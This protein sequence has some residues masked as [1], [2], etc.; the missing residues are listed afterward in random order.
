MALNEDQV[1]LVGTGRDLL[2]GAGTRFD[3]QDEFNPFSTQVRTPQSEDRPYEH[4]ALVGAEWFAER[5]VPI[6][7]IANGADRD[8]PSARRAIQD[9]SAAFAAVGATGEIA[10]LRFRL[11]EDPDE[12]VM[13]GRPRGIDPDTRAIGL[14]YTYV[15][16]A[17]VASD[18]RIYSGTLTSQT[19]G[20]PLQQGGLTLTARPSSTR[21]RLPGDAGAYAS[22]P[23]TAALDIT[24][25][26][27]IEAD[28]N[29]D[30]FA[31]GATQALVSKYTG[32]GNQRSYALWLSGT[33]QVQVVWSTDG[34]TA[35]R[36]IVSSAT[37]VPTTA[38][39][40]RGSLDVNNGAGQRVVTFSYRL[41]DTGPWIQFDQ[42]TIAG[43]TSV[44]AGTALLEIGA[45]TGGAL[46]RF[47]GTVRGARV[48]SVI[49]GTVVANPDFTSQNVKATSFVDSTGKTWTISGTAALV[50]G[51]T[52]RRGLTVPFTIPG[53]LVGGEL[54]LI[55]TGTTDT[56]LRVRI[57]GP[58]VEPRLILRRP[59]GTVQS[60]GF[61]L[62]LL[63]GQW[64]DV[65]SAARTALLNSLP[66][67]NQRGVADWGLDPYPIQPGTNTLRFTAAAYNSDAQITAEHRSAWW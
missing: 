15:S 30:N 47:T 6:R 39:G 61:D 31:T 29:A 41:T 50:G 34:T 49:G 32:T 17:F 52:Y 14:G 20:L 8:V 35:G 59:D 56:G 3:V 19:A 27:E 5:V 43:T 58:A 21:L 48:R 10:E 23:D 28:I 18:P 36:S 11:N 9:M 45:H 1:H 7:V 63:E 13:F 62:E 55:N 54:T 65:D 12:F 16:T 33:G 25:D 46:D 4:G 66:Q 26:F 22:T 51:G 40:V 60:V 24:G 37:A 67:S 44:F 64:L 57:D 38:A 53:Y 2:M 42:Q